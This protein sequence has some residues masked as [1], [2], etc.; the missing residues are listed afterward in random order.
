[1]LSLQVPVCLLAH[2]LSRLST[3]SCKSRSPA[4]W[5]LN[6]LEKRPVKH[7]SQWWISLSALMKAFGRWSILCPSSQFALERQTWPTCSPCMRCPRTRARRCMQQPWSDLWTPSENSMVNEQLQCFKP[8]GNRFQCL[9][10]SSFYS[11][12]ISK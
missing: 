6:A 10:A 8:Y 9:N 11:L 7:R 4:R 12:N 3:V 5:L 1:M 2:V